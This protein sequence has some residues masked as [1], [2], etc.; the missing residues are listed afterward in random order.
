MAQETTMRTPRRTVAPRN[1]DAGG[2][3]TVNNAQTPFGL[4]DPVFV[5]S[6]PRS[7]SSVVGAMIGQHPQM[8]GLPETNLFMAQT[9]KEWWVRC[10]RSV[11]PMEHGLLRAIAQIYFGEQTEATVTLAA[12]WLRRRAHF[13]TEFLFEAI[14]ERMKPL[15]LVD[16]SPR[17]VRRVEF[18]RHAYRMFP[19]ARF[20]HLVR[21]P[22]GQGES[23]MK[24]F[25]YWSGRQPLP[26]SHWM[27]W[28]M[29]DH[30]LGRQRANDVVLDPQQGWHR[31]NVNICQF[32]DSIPDEQKL[33]VRGEDLLRDPD[34]GLRR[35]VDWLGL[36]TDGEAIEMMKHP[37]Q[38]LFACFGPPGARFGNDPFFL[39]NPALR[40]WR[41]EPQSLDGPLTWRDDGQGFLAK[42]RRLAQQF[43][44][45]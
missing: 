10:S 27:I 34:A 43:G 41:G 24:L 29:T 2:E 17:I 44:Y 14:A 42:V 32:L 21:H 11:A 8:Y 18:M 16:K 19:Q 25:K 35:I 31:L 12:A 30:G 4:A 26:P 45:E 33:R 5:L 28:L 7:F 3:P 6:A 13:T 23:M 39:K 36:R 40:P 1:G 38:S 9:L 22:R 20:I 37:E 15:A